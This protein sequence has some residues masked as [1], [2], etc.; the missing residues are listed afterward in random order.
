M[1]SSGATPETHIFS[2]SGF[3]GF[4]DVLSTKQLGRS[5]GCKGLKIPHCHRHGTGCKCGVCSIPDLGTS[6]AKDIA[7]KREKEERF[8]NK[9][10]SSRMAQE[11]RI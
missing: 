9:T 7:K 6:L 10:G 3:Q 1:N 11:K 2:F 5:F 8:Q 4:K